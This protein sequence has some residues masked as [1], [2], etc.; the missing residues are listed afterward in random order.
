VAYFAHDLCPRVPDP[1]PYFPL[2]LL[3]ARRASNAAFLAA[4]L[5][6]MIVS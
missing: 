3:W 2:A 5:Q 4:S 6:A 1:L